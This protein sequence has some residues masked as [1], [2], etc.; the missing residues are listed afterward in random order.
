MTYL[1][2]KTIK[3][4]RYLYRQ[5]SVRKGKKVH[6]ISQFLGAL[7]G[8]IS[9]AALGVSIAKDVMGKGRTEYYTAPLRGTDQRANR[10]QEEYEREL[11]EKDRPAFNAH[12]RN[13]HDRQQRAKDAAKGQP[14]RAK[15]RAAKEAADKK[16]AETMEAVREFNEARDVG[17]GGGGGS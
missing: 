6:T 14:G 1:R 17:K 8:A 16:A 15:Q 2:V 12:V 9:G 4:R 7:D 5:T 11:Y 13:Q 3:G 10:H